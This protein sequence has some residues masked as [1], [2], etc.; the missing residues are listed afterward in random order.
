MNPKLGPTL[1]Y[2]L[3]G[4]L[5]SSCRYS[6]P[7]EVEQA[8]DQ[9]SRPISYSIDIK[10]ILSDRCFHCHGPDA[11]NR[12]A[13]LRL[14][15]EEGIY[16]QN[17]FG[18]RAFVPGSLSASE[19]INRILSHNPQEMMPP[20]TSTLSLTPEEKALLVKWVEQGA[21]W[22]Q[23]WAFIPIKEKVS[24]PAPANDWETKNEVD[25]FI[26]RKLAAQGMLPS[27][28]ASPST[29]LRR[30]SMDLT[31]LPPT[32]ETLSAFRDN[33]SEQ[34]YEQLVD[35]MMQSDAFAERLTLDWLDLARYA[36]SHGLHADGKRNAWPW[37]DWVIDA[38]RENMSYD[39]FVSEQ[40]AGDLMP[41]ATRDQIIA[42]A[43]NRNHPMTAEGG[44]IDEE[45]R[46]EYVSN[47]TNTVGT[48]FMGLTLECAKCHDHKF[49]PISQ[50]EYFQVFSFFNNVKEL[51]MTGNDGDYG[52]MY[53]LTD[54][55][56]D[57][58][59]AFLDR[60]IDSLKHTPAEKTPTIL[61]PALYLGFESLINRELDR[62]RRVKVRGNPE[63]VEGQNGQALSFDHMG[64]VLQI[65]ELGAY[66]S[67]DPFSVAMWIKPMED[68]R[69]TKQLIGNTRQKEQAWRGWEFGLDSSNH[70][71]FKLIGALPDDYI[72]VVSKDSIPYQAWTHLTASYDGSMSASGVNLYVN[73]EKV[74]VS[75]EYDNLIGS[76]QFI[77]W[78]KKGQLPTTLSIAKAF[79]AFTGDNG[80]YHGLM[81]E[82]YLFDGEVLAE[83]V[84]KLY[85]RE[86]AGPLSLLANT[87]QGGSQGQIMAL[88]RQKVGMYDTIPKLM[89]MQEMPEMRAT[90]T[91]ER[92]EYDKPL[93]RVF[94]ATISSVLPFDTTQY[95]RNR[96]GF[97]KWLFDANNPLTA[98]VAVN[99][100]WQMIFGRGIVS[101]SNDF[102]N[103]GALPTHPEL[104]D[105]LAWEFVSSGWD[106]R[107]LLKLMVMSATYRQSS[108]ILPEHLEKDR[109]N[110]WLARSPSYRWPAEFVRD[111]ALAASGLLNPK[112]GGE[113]ARPYQPDGLWIEV[114]NF[115]Q[116]LLRFTK[117]EDDNQ[118]RR[119]MYTFIRR[120]APP[121]FMTI[122][123]APSREVCIVSRERTNTPL[124]AL[125]LLNDPQF[126]ELS[127]ALACR[128]AENEAQSLDEKISQGFQW[129]LTREPSRDEVTI[130]KK[131][132]QT[133]LDTFAH[134]PQEADKLLK[135]GD[136]QVPINL[137]KQ[138]IAA[139]TVVANTLFNMDEM[140]T[141]R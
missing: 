113:S 71:S 137:D 115:S 35:Q 54:G 125:V 122:F 63:L 91:L 93:E 76:I 11:E 31:G 112:V 123:D 121:P 42:T 138:E 16:A 86:R 92:G 129:V 105:W 7:E 128:M 106:V 22:Q 119:S 2:L 134:R 44:V 85:E 74:P 80:I 65:K 118:Y 43:F 97:S 17:A 130:M 132:Y 68:S 55:A 90:Y 59:I 100:Y 108:R 27:K 15:T 61:R 133:Q 88:Q 46:L 114:G 127:K 110:K 75:V 1:L 102:G 99:R 96:L 62:N 50:K 98:R 117:D 101:T 36:D 141:K 83:E 26:H 45:V 95:E 30:L 40:L 111:N 78:T 8:Y 52:P 53:P 10:P 84:A 25:A 57:S 29:L 12:K 104:L 60:Q 49:D 126:V 72:Q 34:A 116:D 23:H 14:D 56:Q 87:N 38:F 58:I 32:L 124:Q 120:T 21:E 69:K 107:H 82:L 47:R 5:L 39:Q 131:L 89:V 139:L 109:E 66:R 81:D 51:G 41:D 103:Q 48:A 24:V 19:A 79:R 94:P 67:T 64:S 3:I 6:L 135:T 20:A 18:N 4:V 33:P 70:F 140:Y 136:H 77:P 73:G 28:E 37:R 9:I 13:G